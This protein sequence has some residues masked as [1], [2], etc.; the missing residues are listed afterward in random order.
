M[1]ACL[2]GGRHRPEGLENYLGISGTL[3]AQRLSVRMPMAPKKPDKN[4]KLRPLCVKSLHACTS[5]LVQR[6]AQPKHPQKFWNLK[7][8]KAERTGAY[9]A[10]RTRQKCKITSIVRKIFARLCEP[11]CAAVGTGRKVW[12]TTSE[13]TLQFL[14]T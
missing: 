2:F 10:Q 14:F 9:G 12:K 3:Y 11:A 5:Q 13:V 6:Q 1:R 7:W 4:V 8:P